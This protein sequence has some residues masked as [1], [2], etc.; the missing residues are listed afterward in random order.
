MHTATTVR[1]QGVLA[2]E[3]V[4]RISNVT[5]FLTAVR[6]ER[7]NNDRTDHLTRITNN[8]ELMSDVNS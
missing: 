2:L 7:F 3:S 6:S 1:K 5:L 4:G 8:L